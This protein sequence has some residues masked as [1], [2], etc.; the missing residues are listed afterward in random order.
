MARARW[1]PAQFDWQNIII[2]RC[3]SVT[4]LKTFV[5]GQICNTAVVAPYEICKADTL[6]QDVWTASRQ[7]YQEARY[8][9]ARVCYVTGEVHPEKLRV[10]LAYRY[11][12]MYVLFCRKNVM[13]Y[14]R[15]RL[16]YRAN[17]STRYN[18]IEVHQDMLLCRKSKKMRY[19]RGKVS[20]GNTH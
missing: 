19:R 5:P 10:H 14:P 2:I 20:T 7:R 12:G 15:R 8:V 3:Q 16:R 4:I 11:N 1:T 17:I 13:R 9:T 18:V 6:C